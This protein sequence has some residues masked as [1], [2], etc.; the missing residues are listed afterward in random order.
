MKTQ[1]DRWMDRAVNIVPPETANGIDTK[2]WHLVDI[3]S[4][5]VISGLSYW[6]F[7]VTTKALKRRKQIKSL[8]GGETGQ[9]E[10]TPF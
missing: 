9:T 7:S 10:V 8:N 4:C 6:S 5:K 2:C 3:L 1:V